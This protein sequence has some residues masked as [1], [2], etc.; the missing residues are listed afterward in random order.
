VRSLQVEANVK[1]SDLLV[2]YGLLGIIEDSPMPEFS[3]KDSDECD[4]FI[5]AVMRLAFAQGKQRDD[6]WIAD[7]VASRLTKD[8]LR[9]WIKLD[10]ETQTSWKLLRRAMDLKYQPLFRGG[11]GEDAEKFVEMVYQRARDAGKQGDNRWIME[12]VP[13]FLS[14]EALRW[15]AS[16]DRTARTEWDSF[17]QAA[18]AR[19]SREDWQS[20]RTSASRQV[21]LLARLLATTQSKCLF[22]LSIVPTPAAAV[23]IAQLRNGRLRGRIRFTISSLPSHYYVSKKVDWTGYFTVTQSL[24]EALEVEHDPVFEDL[25]TLYIAEV[26]YS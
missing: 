7:F 24:G 13:T 11:S 19:Y 1:K 6:A 10:D 17:Q 22:L 21:K 5:S 4:N 16:L 12:F 2:T 14:G 15:Y 20:S 25:T 26:R 23:P 9:G 3:G 18:F 8:A